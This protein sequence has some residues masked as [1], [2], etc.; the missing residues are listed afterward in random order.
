MSREEVVARTSLLPILRQPERLPY[1]FRWDSGRYNATTWHTAEDA[2]ETKLELQVIAITVEH[3]H[4]HDYDYEGS[5]DAR[6][7]PAKP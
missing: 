7:T 2:A 5:C 3:E 1:N 4:E 6:H